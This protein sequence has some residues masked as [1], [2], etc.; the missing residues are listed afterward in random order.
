MAKTE[1]LI[2]NVKA[3]MLDIKLAK[4][5]SSQSAELSWKEQ[6]RSLPAKRALIML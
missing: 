3:L 6:E 2:A 5:K 4:S 1:A